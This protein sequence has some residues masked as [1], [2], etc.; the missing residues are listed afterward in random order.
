MPEQ[1][2]NHRSI[3]VDGKEINS[4]RIA[5]LQPI[6]TLDEGEFNKLITNTSGLS[7]WAKRFLLISMGWIVKVLSVFLIFFY[8]FFN[9]KPEEKKD[10]KIDLESWEIG[11]IV[12]ALGICLLLFL[13]S[14]MFKSEKGRLIKSIKTYYQE[15]NSKK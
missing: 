10:I 15:N 7:E 3:Q 6:Y 1:N 12:I 14:L 2:V 9:A 13:L 5:V 11:S 8:L 4:D